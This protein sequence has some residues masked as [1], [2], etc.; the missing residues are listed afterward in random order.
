MGGNL[1]DLGEA[2]FWG[3]AETWASIALAMALLLLRV[4]TRSQ[5]FETHDFVIGDLESLRLR[6]SAS[7]TSIPFFEWSL[8]ANHFVRVV[9]GTHASVDSD[10][11]LAS[12]QIFLGTFLALAL[13]AGLDVLGRHLEARRLRQ[14]VAR[15]PTTVILVLGT[16]LMDWL[17][18]QLGWWALIQDH[19]GRQTASAW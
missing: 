13:V 18:S 3:L 10:L 2:T 1:L 19:V 9:E 8:E 14:T 12:M 4:W 5:K 17:V 7:L 11:L 16:V 6:R 15:P